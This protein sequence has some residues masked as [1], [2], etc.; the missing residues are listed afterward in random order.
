[1]VD[2]V[3]DKSRLY[4]TSSKRLSTPLIITVVL[5]LAVLLGGGDV[6]YQ[7]QKSAQNI[8]SPLPTPSE[9]TPTTTPSPTVVTTPTGSPS[10][11]GAKTTTTP[12]PTPRPT[13]VLGTTDR[14]KV[15]VTVLNGSGTSGAASKVADYL[16]GLGYT[17]SSTGNADSFDYEN[18]TIS[19]KSAKKAILPQLQKDLSSQGTVDSTSTTFTGTADAQVI[20]GQ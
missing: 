6:F 1:M 7:S 14:S 10:P 12:S 19:V 8:E 4:R 5:L 18:L 2:E 3:Q 15:T 9:V 16:E 20:V 11:T 17:I 13:G